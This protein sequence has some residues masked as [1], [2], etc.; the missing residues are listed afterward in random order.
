MFQ[1]VFL[2]V[3]AISAA[4]TTFLSVGD[5]GGAALGEPYSGQAM[6]VAREMERVASGGAGAK[7]VLNTGDN[8]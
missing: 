7:W 5:W 3:S 6:A 4:T 2:C 1:F 8:F